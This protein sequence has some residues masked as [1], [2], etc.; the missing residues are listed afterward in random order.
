MSG[1]ICN[2]LMLDKNRARA[3]ALLFGGD[4]SDEMQIFDFRRAQPRGGARRYAQSDGRGF[5]GGQGTNKCGSNTPSPLPHKC[6]RGRRI[7]VLRTSRRANWVFDLGF[8]ESLCPSY[9][10]VGESVVGGWWLLAGW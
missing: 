8:F 3:C 5:R 9:F 2:F 10:V 4:I 6:V 1:R 7:K